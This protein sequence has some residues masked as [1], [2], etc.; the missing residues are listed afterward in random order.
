[1]FEA[2]G[3]NRSESTKLNY[4]RN[5]KQAARARLEI[6]ESICTRE[7]KRKPSERDYGNYVINREQTAPNGQNV[8]ETGS[9]P[10]E[11]EYIE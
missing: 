5:R 3:S 6:I 10:L 1:M 9:T 2:Q 4:M 8:A 11:R 7:T